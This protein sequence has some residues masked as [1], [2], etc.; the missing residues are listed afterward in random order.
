MAQPI[1]SVTQFAVEIVSARP[2]AGPAAGNSFRCARVYASNAS[3]GN[4][5]SLVSGSRPS[6]QGRA[7]N[8]ALKPIAQ[9]RQTPV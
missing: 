6:A 3:A 9:E 7:H 8:R 4:L 5:A 2:L 1:Y